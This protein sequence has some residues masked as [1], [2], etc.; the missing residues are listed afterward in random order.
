MP[1]SSTLPTSPVFMALSGWLPF[2]V[3]LREAPQSMGTGRVAK[4]GIVCIAENISWKTY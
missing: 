4:I 2:I 1:L 3:E